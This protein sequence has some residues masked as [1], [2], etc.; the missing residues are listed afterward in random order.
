MPSDL[1]N[2]SLCILIKTCFKHIRIEFLSLFKFT[3][4]SCIK[5]GTIMECVFDDLKRSPIIGSK[6]AVP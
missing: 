1:S 5:T 3:F 6:S 2:I 4:L